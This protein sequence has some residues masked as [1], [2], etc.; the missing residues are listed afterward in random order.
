MSG[1]ELAAALFLL[2]ITSI[3][4]SYCIICYYE[5]WSAEV[6]REIDSVFRELAL[7]HSPKVIWASLFSS[8]VEKRRIGNRIETGLVELRAYENSMG[9]TESEFIVGP[10]LQS[11]LKREFH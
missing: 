1:F 8:D 6:R 4:Y 11:V 7:R 5:E 2:Y 9:V 10:S 3:Y